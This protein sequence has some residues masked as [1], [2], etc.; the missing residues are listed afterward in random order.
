MDDPLKAGMVFSGIPLP[1]RQ[2]PDL[3]AFYERAAEVPADKPT[4]PCDENA[5]HDRFLFYTGP[6][7]AERRGNDLADVVEDFTVPSPS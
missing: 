7:T 1:A 6:A 4:G 3:M 5:R 2:R